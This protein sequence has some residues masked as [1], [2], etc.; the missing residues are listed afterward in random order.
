MLSVPDLPD[1]TRTILVQ[2]IK[3]RFLSSGCEGAVIGIS[4]GLD[5]ALVYRLSCEA[6]GTDKVHPVFL[7]NGDLSAPDR[8]F[9]IMV[10][11]ERLREIDI[12]ALVDAYPLETEGVVRANLQARLRMTVLYTLANMNSFLVLGTSNKTEL[13]LGYFTKHGDGASDICPLGDVFKTQARDL[14]REIGVPSPIID[15]VPT[16]GLIVG[17]TDEGDLG[18]PYPVLD[19][20]ILG[21]LRFWEPERVAGSIDASVSSRDEIQRSGF[22]PPITPVHVRRVYSMIE[23]ARHKRD[24]LI[25]PKVQGSTVGIDLRERW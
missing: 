3:D 8:E 6:L 5:S 22:E 1:E 14:A 25:V 12:S 18:L 7:P 10:A 20:I 15:R 11:G 21:Y 23:S 17:Q 24:P 4:G 16:A 9:A 2:F 13:M 19:R